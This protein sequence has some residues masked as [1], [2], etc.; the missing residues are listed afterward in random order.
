MPAGLAAYTAAAA[1]ATVVT[2]A[3]AGPIGWVDLGLTA[4]GVSLGVFI[5]TMGRSDSAFSDMTASIREMDQAMA[6]ANAQ[7]AASEQDIAVA[8]MTAGAYIDRL[9]ALEQAGTATGASQREYAAILAEVQRLLPGVNIELDEQTGL[10]ENGAA[11]LRDLADGWKQA[12]RA[13]VYY[14]AYTE[15]A[16][17][18]FA[19]Q[20]DVNEAQEKLNS[21]QE[22]LPA[23]LGEIEAKQRALNFAQAKYNAL[24]LEGIGDFDVY[25][26]MMRQYDDQIIEL[27]EDIEGLYGAMTKEERAAMAEQDDLNAA[28]SAGREAMNQYSAEMNTLESQLS[29]FED[30]NRDGADSMDGM[31]GSIK[32]VMDHLSDLSE[33]Y[34]E[35]YR[36]ALESI[37]GQFSL[38]EEAPTIVDGSVQELTKALESQTTYWT[39]YSYNLDALNSRNIE[40]LDSYIRHIADGSTKS[41]G[42]IAALSKAGDEDLQAIVE[43]WQALNEAQESSADSLALTKTN[44]DGMLDE[45]TGKIE[46]AVDEMNLSYEA[47]QA[48]MQ[49]VSSYID[50]ADGMVGSVRSAYVRVANAARD[51]LQYGSMTVITRTG[52]ENIGRVGYAEGT[53]YASPGWR[54]VGENGPEL[55]RFQGGEQVVPHTKSVELLERSAEPA[56]VNVTY[57]PVYNITGGGDPQDIRA[58]LEEHDRALPGLIT[59]ILRDQQRVATR[60]AYM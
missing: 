45:M 39:Q 11:S 44:F 33:A 58:I 25:D 50:A 60:R 18:Y 8:A 16:K 23:S 7:M 19:V 15:K 17:A 29:G 40:G 12:A 31:N 26:Q 20:K 28:I 5:A 51:A 46:D 22:Q 9:E 10:V 54:W 38:W 53:D 27:Q 34:G 37:Q 57:A 1:A 35:A 24:T 55:M 52:G 3:L 21:L 4:L 2:S 6:D 30:A 41:A 32:E 14:E 49:T 56:P 42:Y 48:A 43:S 13:Q 59:T 47:R 36:D